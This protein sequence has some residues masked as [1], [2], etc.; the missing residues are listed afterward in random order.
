MNFGTSAISV[1]FDI[2]GTLMLTGGAGLTAMRQTMN[3]LYG[4]EEFPSLIYHGRT[5]CAIVRDLFQHAGMP[6]E[7]HYVSFRE[8]YHLLLLQALE[9]R[10]G[11]LL[12][13]VTEL[14]EDISQVA[15][16]SL[17]VLTGNARDA[18]SMKLKNYGIDHFFEYGG[19]GD[20]HADRSDVARE[21]V[22][23][24]ATILGPRFDPAQIVV[25]GD[26][27]AD[28]ACAK[29]IRAVSIA[30]ATGGSTM[31]ELD[32]TNPDLLLKSLRELTPSSIVD[33]VERC[34]CV[35]VR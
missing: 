7:D 13:G 29:A 26:T 6:F 25:I 16:F 19:Y 31:E 34:R 12:P 20:F 21:A 1:L 23:Q 2:D 32:A 30:V 28:V 15:Q 24:A 10:K 22:Q 27:P 14:L 17:G 35:R 3:Q 4:M 5:D 8:T 9:E 33:V 11:Y 18:A